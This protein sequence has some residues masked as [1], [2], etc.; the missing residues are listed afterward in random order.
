LFFA[1]SLINAHGT[2]PRRQQARRIDDQL[3]D[4]DISVGRDERRAG[5]LIT[6]CGT[7]IGRAGS[8]AERSRPSVNVHSETC[9]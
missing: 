2:A 8:F 3:R 9:Q 6:R 7:V 4:G 1:T 5:P